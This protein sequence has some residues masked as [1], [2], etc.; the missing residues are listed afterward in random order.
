MV[1]QISTVSGLRF[2]AVY[3][4]ASRLSVDDPDMPILTFASDFSI[5]H[6]QSDTA[7][8]EGSWHMPGTYMPG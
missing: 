8:D 3:H 6:Q 1:A 4:T 5:V 7:I 2:Y